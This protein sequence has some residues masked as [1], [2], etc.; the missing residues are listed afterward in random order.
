MNDRPHQNLGITLGKCWQTESGGLVFHASVTLSPQS[1]KEKGFLILSP[2]SFGTSISFVKEKPQEQMNANGAAAIIRKYCPS[3]R[4]HGIGLSPADHSPNFLRLRLKTNTTNAEVYIVLSGKP[5]EQ[6]DFIV[7]GTSLARMQP[8]KTFTVRKTASSA[9]LNAVDL[10]ENQFFLWMSSLAEAS[11]NLAITENAIEP[12][13]S[14]ERRQARDRIAR[15]LKTLRKTLAQDLSKMPAAEAI[16][17]AKE[18]ARLLSNY[19]WLVKPGT[20]ELR[21]DSTQ[22]GAVPRVIEIHPDKSPGENLEKLF[23]QIKKLERGFALQGERSEK[24]K[25][26][27]HLYEL[28]LDKVKNPDIPLPPAETNQLMID[29]GL[30]QAK[31]TSKHLKPLKT[32]TPGLGRTFLLSDQVLLT[33]GRDAKESDQI[34]KS[35]KS[36]DWWIHIAGGGRGSHVIVSGLPTKAQIPV[37]VLSAAGILALHFSER[38]NAMEGEVYCTRRQFIRKQKGLAAGLWLVDKSETVLIRY[39]ASDLA[40]IFSKELRAG[41]QRHKALD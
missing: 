9:F 3:A 5:D 8:K 28:A 24:I 13:L 17:S 39:S 29:L 22:T 18:D 14:T 25:D 36:S 1:S 20:H 15:R 10:S 31:V 7:D 41:I 40:D 23:I 37:S 33:L 11:S 30:A 6:I 38:S 4:V 35:A 21:L 19:L 27:I 26:Q 34:V 12:I 16:Q 32:T 2:T